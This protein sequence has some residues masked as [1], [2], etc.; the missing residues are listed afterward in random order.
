[1]V[2]SAHLEDD[3]KHTISH[4]L[5]L[6]VPPSFLLDKL[7]QVE[8]SRHSL[9]AI[10]HALQLRLADLESRLTKSKGE[11]TM[12]AVALRK[13]IAESR[14]LE[15]QLKQVSQRCNWL[16][17]ECSLYHNDREV[18]LGV[19]E[20]AE[21][22]ACKAE[23]QCAGMEI[24]MAQLFNDSEELQK[25][26]MEN[27]QGKEEL[28]RLGSRVSHLETSNSNLQ[29]ELSK[30]EKKL[31]QAR[32]SQGVSTGHIDFSC[33]KDAMLGSSSLNYKSEHLLN[34]ERP[35]TNQLMAEVQR[36]W[37]E[38]AL[39]KCNLARAEIQVRIL[40]DDNKDLRSALRS[41]T[42]TSSP[43]VSKKGKPCSSLFE[44]M[45]SKKGGARQPLTLL[46]SN[47]MNLR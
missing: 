5:G 8:H 33:G 24:K 13:Q 7:C 4:L 11:A 42:S 2:L 44:N 34:K 47:M 21:D 28:D 36:L 31:A 10:V 38:V 43:H 37:K 35:G 39:Y 19:A 26:R 6:P 15:G 22:R 20:E 16:E 12:T 32:D 45:S 40:D 46:E 23:E 29:V 41:K 30:A 27:A 9:Q 17:E 25:I 18:F 1:M 3:L 14:K